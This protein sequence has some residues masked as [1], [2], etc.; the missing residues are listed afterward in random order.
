MDDNKFI[1]LHHSG[2]DVYQHHI[3]LSTKENINDT[4][5]VACLVLLCKHCW[6]V[7]N[8]NQKNSMNLSI[9]FFSSSRRSVSTLPMFNFSNIKTSQLLT[10]LLLSSCMLSFESSCRVLL[11]GPFR[12]NVYI[13]ICLICHC[14]H[15][16]EKYTTGERGGDSKWQN[17]SLLLFSLP[18]TDW[19][20][21]EWKHK[22]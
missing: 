18:A 14:L 22:I 2:D 3:S 16:I 13:W 7:S 17:F 21:L 20:W 11:C 4:R 5:N 10:R 6:R 8:D 9:T 1:S 19:G 15:F 12:E